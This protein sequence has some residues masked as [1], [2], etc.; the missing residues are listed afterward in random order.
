[1]P[2]VGAIIVSIATTVATG[3]AAAFTAIGGWAGIASFLASPFGSLLIRYW[4]YSL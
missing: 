2:A 1:M 3:V 4:P